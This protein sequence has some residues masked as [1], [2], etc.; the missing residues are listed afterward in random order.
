MRDDHHADPQPG[1]RATIGNLVM[2]RPFLPVA[3]CFTA[4]VLVAHTLN[5]PVTYWLFPA[6]AFVIAA[7]TGARTGFWLLL[8]L[9]VFAGAAKY[10]VETAVIAPDDLRNL[11]R[12]EPQ[13]AIVRG[14]LVE[15]PYQRVF[16]RDGT[17]HWRT[18]A[19]IRLEA[20][21][22]DG[23]WTTTV[24]DVI[25]TTP[26][27][28]AN[29]FYDGQ[30]VQIDGV[31][32][33]PPKALAPG[34]FDYRRYLK[35]VGVHYQMS[36]SSTN[37]WQ[38]L[39][40]PGALP[41][42]ARFASW[43][44]DMLA[45]GLPHD[46]YLDLLWTM[47]LGW[48]TG[49]SGEV[50]EPFMRSGTMHV[51]A[52]SGLHIALIAAILIA[53]LRLVGCRRTT[54]AWIVI[55]LIWLYT[56][57]TG[58]QASAIRSTIMSSIIILGWFWR[59]PSDLLNSLMAA[60]FAILV[61]DPLQL[62]QAGFQ[63]SF[64]VVL[65]L[66]LLMPALDR[67][68]ARMLAFDPFLPPQ[69]RT[70]LLRWSN[71][72][73]HYV[74]A[75]FAVSLAA[76]L[77]SLPLIAHYFHLLTPISLLANMIVVP[78]SSGA[79]A[80][81]LAT[82]A[83]GAICPPAAELFNNCAWLLMVLM[84]KISEWAAAIPLLVLHVRGPSP[85]TFLFYYTL[86]IALFSGWLF[87]AH[88][89]KWAAS[90]VVAA[91]IPVAS[92][93]WQPEAAS[94]MTVLPL[95]GGSAVY[96]NHK[97]QWLIDC[98][99]NEFGRLITKP[100]LQA[101]AINHLPHL[102]LTH[103]DVRHVEAAPLIYNTFSR[104]A[105]YMSPVRFLSG[106]YRKVQAYFRTNHIPIK[107]ISA[108]DRVGIWD[109]LHPDEGT[110]F[111]Q[112]DDNAIVLFAN[113]FGHRVL[114]LTDLGTAGQNALLA[115]YPDLRADIVVTGLPRE[116]QPVADGFLDMVQPQIIVIADAEE[117]QRARDRLRNRLAKR[118]TQ[119]L[120]TSDRGALTF[121]FYKSGRLKISTP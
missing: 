52:I 77:G 23:Q 79:L 87:R 105:V 61:W 21:A 115:R 2:R 11:L 13:Q 112:A 22:L 59:R 109:V 89:R 27:I 53:A 48:K 37:E 40:A 91:V 108:G 101:Q 6:F 97:E 88:V 82:L 107:T 14:T 32:R 15:T 3:M 58:W 7:V 116:S 76:W 70:R 65:A 24:G 119:V 85:S 25:V 20:I 17:E 8:P 46:R 71:F 75:S 86:L 60:G 102:V 35:T 45:R 110:K 93:F 38:L 96:V 49:L 51:F 78:L 5:L 74:V 73:A 10:T 18:L 113:I 111:P 33:Q 68:R 63:L 72:A 100:F 84:V 103:G 104:P 26:D 56:G 98:G 69:F 118:G 4:G 121:S 81:N 19:R 117:P 16:N 29:T 80:C 31:I 62:F 42:S 64:F 43:A 67:L 99:G 55:P 50:S 83:V 120:Y 39:S 57:V 41:F 90:A 1:V 30:R 44:C 47:T 54:C 92:Q 95:H 28:L 34:L 36:V 106:P 114:L 9:L 66:A 12:T 94:Q